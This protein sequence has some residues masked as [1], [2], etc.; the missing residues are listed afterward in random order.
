MAA[1]NFYGVLP[2]EGRYDAMIPSFFS[3]SNKTKQFNMQST[4]PSMDG[5]V[6]DAKW[7]NG[8]GGKKILIIARY[9]RELAFLQYTKE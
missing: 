9:A 4:L 8:A 5:E 2:F 1:G 6:R 3:Y 7:I